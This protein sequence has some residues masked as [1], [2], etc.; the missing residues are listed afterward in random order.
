MSAMLSAEQLQFKEAVGRFFDEVSPASTVRA[1]VEAEAPFARD[2]WQRASTELGL[3]GV[4]LPEEFGGAGFGARELGIVCEEMGRTL[5]TGPYFGSSVMASYAVLFFGSE[6]AKARHLP[7]F[8][9]G[10]SVG[11]LALDSLDKETRIGGLLKGDEMHRLHGRV[12]VLVGGADADVVFALADGPGGVGLYRLL[13]K[14]SG[15]AMVSRSGL[16]ATRRLSTLELSNTAAERLGIAQ[17]AQMTKF[18]DHLCVALAHEQIGGAQALFDSTVAYTKS[19]YQFGRPIGSFQALKH[20]CADLLL[21]LELAKS[22]VYEAAA[23]LDRGE[24]A[25][26]LASMAKAMGSESYMNVARAAIQLRGGIGF[27]WEDNT[28]LWFKRAKSSEVFMGTPSYHRDRMLDH[29]REAS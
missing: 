4:H 14:P 23:C 17:P 11:V 6:D 18:F 16:D 9:S 8:A 22:V 28:H 15:L 21:E 2:V 3:M 27:T 7:A 12:P 5:Y 20:R 29:V 26:E 1:F 19:R 24:P 10:E 13:T 25:S